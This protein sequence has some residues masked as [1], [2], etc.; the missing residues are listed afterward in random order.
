MVE[1][2]NKFLQFKCQIIQF[3]NLGVTYEVKCEEDLDVE[4]LGL[5]YLSRS[6]IN[7][8]IWIQTSG[9]KRVG[10][11]KGCHRQLQG[12]EGARGRPLQ[13]ARGPAHWS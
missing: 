2:V 9:S 3:T 1:V 12:A 13:G 8:P 4:N 6:S 5:Q 10:G 7:C 11:T